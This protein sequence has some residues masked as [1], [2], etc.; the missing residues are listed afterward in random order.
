M[1]KYNSVLTILVCV[2]LFVNT[3]QATTLIINSDGDA[4]LADS[5]STSCDTGSSVEIPGAGTVAECTL[6]AA[7]EAANNG[8]GIIEVEY[9][10]TLSCG[11]LNPI[12]LESLLPD[13]QTSIQIDG[14]THPCSGSV[15]D[16]YPIVQP[17]NL[18]V[19]LDY[20][21]RITGSDVVI[22]R[23]WFTGGGGFDIDAIQIANAQDVVIRQVAATSNPGRGIS[24]FSS[25]AVEVTDSELVGNGVG[26][27]ARSNVAIGGES[28][29]IVLSGN[30]IRNSSLNGV[31]VTLGA[32]AAIGQIVSLTPIPACVGNTISGNSGAGVR[33]DD[34]GQAAI[35]CNDILD[36][37]GS[38]VF[39]DSDDNTV[40]SATD[41][42]GPADPFGN[43]IAAN[44]EYG[45]FV[46]EGASDSLIG[47]NTIGGT[48]DDP[49]QGN[50]E[51]GIHVEGGPTSI[52]LNTI[53]YNHTGVT[54][55][56]QG[57]TRIRGNSIMSNDDNGI[58]SERNWVHIGG[59][60]EAEANVIGLNSTAGIWYESPGGNG[61][62][63]IAGNYI[64]TNADGDDL[65]NAGGGIVIRNTTT[66][67]IGRLM[68]SGVDPRPN[69]IGFNQNGIFL[70]HVENAQVT[71]NYIG[72]NADGDNLG[73]SG[74]GV[75]VAMTE[76]SQIGAS[77]TAGIQPPIDN[78]GN[79]IANNDTGVQVSG[80]GSSAIDNSIRGNS[81]HSNNQG[82]N[83]SGGG[84][85][86]DPG[87]GSTGPNNLQNFP[88]I[89]PDQTWYNDSTG[90]VHFR[91]RVQ[92][93]AG[94]AEYPLRV[95]FYL[96]D[97]NSPQGQIFLGTV[98][99]QSA[100]ANTWEVGT[101]QPPSGV[102][103]SGWMTATATDNNGN[104]SQ[105]NPNPVSLDDG[106]PVDLI[107]EDRFE[108]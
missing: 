65:G 104:T 82:I 3:A 60:D 74:I 99:Y 98:V 54:V 72:T 105:F 35:R 49:G 6:R 2:G 69:V 85:E 59:E 20:G 11:D 102:N 32:E 103:V 46:T 91:H 88:E 61:F 95:D 108:E 29:G 90:M 89:D 97:D 79:I 34:D 21:L 58:W 71:N 57:R 47:R 12:Q 52:Q 80:A 5:G 33:V 8:N 70:H 23:M 68:L 87:G 86:V 67:L 26:E 39:L 22:E 4:G 83:L 66:A 77:A 9:A 96:A 94:N 13:I 17:A 73:N 14:E 93:N 31:H 16:H 75:S 24:V 1:R 101:F 107:F 64:G 19:D 56:N 81:F 43:T 40:G 10:S 41:P 25:S 18:G 63:G 84:D 37:E 55:A 27:P 50:G 100:S 76:S 62:P 28:S 53:S 106:S 36:N 44:E 30:E 38:G 51:S 48:D 92:T 78:A 45:V 7:I 15:L 42:G